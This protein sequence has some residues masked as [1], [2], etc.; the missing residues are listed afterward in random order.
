MVGDGVVLCDHIA[1]GSWGSWLVL[2]GPMWGGS[3]GVLVGIV[4]SHGWWIF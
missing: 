4:G 2:A 1:G 3:W